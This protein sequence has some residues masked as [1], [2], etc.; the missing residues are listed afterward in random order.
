MTDADLGEID[1][2][3]PVAPF[4]AGVM[5]QLSGDPTLLETKYEAHQ[6]LPWRTRGVAT[7]KP[8]SGTKPKLARGGMR[9]RGGLSSD[10]A[11]AWF[12]HKMLL[13]QP[14]DKWS[15]LGPLPFPEAHRTNA[16]HVFKRYSRNVNFEYDM[17]RRP[18]D[19]V[20]RSV[21][22]PDEP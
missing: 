16:D 10:E 5:Q 14:G 3:G 17:K 6:L 15:M 13:R 22:V 12:V 21:R 19:P 7:L 18:L 9:E 1:M 20:A 2:S 4:L 11:N 8:I